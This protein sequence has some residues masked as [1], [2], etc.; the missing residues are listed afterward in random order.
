MEIG[1]MGSISPFLPLRLFPDRIS[2][3]PLIPAV[4]LF[5]QSATLTLCTAPHQRG[6][7]DVII[8]SELAVV[9]LEVPFHLETTL[10]L[11]RKRTVVEN[12]RKC[13]DVRWPIPLECLEVGRSS[14]Y[15]SALSACLPYLVILVLISSR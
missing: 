12:V 15:P 1:E 9:S 6:A 11:D 5:F 4:S 8:S 10:V 2:P 3:P 13:V 14:V 7:I